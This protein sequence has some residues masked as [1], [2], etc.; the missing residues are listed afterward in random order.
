MEEVALVLD[1]ADHATVVGKVGTLAG[2]II[3]LKRQLDGDRVVGGVVKVDHQDG[4]GDWR[5]TQGGVESAMA[6][7]TCS[8]RTDGRL[9]FLLRYDLDEVEACWVDPPQRRGE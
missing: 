2:P 9:T 4:V 3:D 7:E 1:P 5:V 8:T 6:K